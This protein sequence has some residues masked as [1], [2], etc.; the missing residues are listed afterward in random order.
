MAITP[1]NQPPRPTRSGTEFTLG[2]GSFVPQGL[3]VA[4][5][6]NV[7]RDIPAGPILMATDVQTLQFSTTSNPLA[8]NASETF[9]SQ[10]AFTGFGQVKPL[11]DDVLFAQVT[12]MPSTKT[13]GLA[14]GQSSVVAT[15]RD[16]QGKVVSGPT[17]PAGN[18]YNTWG[19]SV[20]VS[21]TNASGAG[22]AQGALVF[23]QVTVNL[24]SIS[25]KAGFLTNVQTGAVSV[26]GSS[27][28]GGS[29][30]AQGADHGGALGP[31]GTGGRRPL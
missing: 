21:V 20:Q 17:F 10:V 2:Q 1:V 26:V 29:G 27:G 7:S 30:T 25:P 31:G 22:I 19:A 13:T 16:I 11:P 8:A 4:Q 12:I 5:V 23:V 14:I 3:P 24:L 15:C 9:T 6:G 28:Q 18:Q